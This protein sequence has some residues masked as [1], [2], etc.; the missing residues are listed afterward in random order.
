[1]VLVAWHRQQIQRT[2]VAKVTARPV[3]ITLAS[4]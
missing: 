1:M 3:E 2:P 4:V